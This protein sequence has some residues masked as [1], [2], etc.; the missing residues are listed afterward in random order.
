MRKAPIGWENCLVYG[1]GGHAKTVLATIEALGKYKVLF[2]LDDDA[3]RHNR[4]H[5]GHRV[6]GGREKLAE[7]VDQGVAYG[8]VAVG[9]N[10]K[11]AE[12]AQALRESGIELM[13]A[14]HPTAA[15]LGGCHIGAGAAVLAHA[16]IGAD[17]V[18][19]EN[20]IISV[21]AVVGHDSQVGSFAQLCPQVALA[22]QTEVGDYSF[23]GM[24]AAILPGVRVGS[25]VIVGA[26]AVVNRDLPDGVTAVGAPA[27]IIARRSVEP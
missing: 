25:R 20:A 2:L 13:R 11:R 26:N 5:Y 9:D 15:L 1:A 10:A 8:I 4:V 21:G 23:I 12:L 17:A 14:I 7:I 19:G 22:G 6:S 18:I 24:G 27:R 16:F 3:A